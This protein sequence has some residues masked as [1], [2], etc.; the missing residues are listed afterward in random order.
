M[1]CATD[2]ALAYV[3]DNFT[4]SAGITAFVGI[5]ERI[6]PPIPAERLD[7]SRM[8]RA[9]WESQYGGRTPEK[10]SSIPHPAFAYA[11]RTTTTLSGK[12][13]SSI[14]VEVE[15]CVSVDKW[16]GDEIRIQGRIVDG[17]FLSGR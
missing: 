8:V 7:L 9:D 2:R 4:P 5:V 15:P 11:I 16:I 14:L 12:V 10:F 6:E 13:P 1:S 3:D 17:I